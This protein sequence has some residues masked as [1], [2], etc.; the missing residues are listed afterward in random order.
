MPR[1]KKSRRLKGKLNLKTGSKKDFIASEDKGKIP[2][3]NK[4]AKHKKRP[5]SAY[6]KYLE[7]TGKSDESA[8]SVQQPE[9]VESAEQNIDSL[10]PQEVIKPEKKKSFDDLSG[11]EL[12]DML[13]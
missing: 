7:Q 3:K 10:E 6:Q 8:G 2:S 13:D 4:L 1:Q 9:V 5:K 12:L 11:D